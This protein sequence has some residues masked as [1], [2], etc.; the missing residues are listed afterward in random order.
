MT[1]STT[2][3]GERLVDAREI[4]PRVRH[5][6]IL[7]MFGL[8][9]PGEGFRI[10]NDHDPRRLYFEFQAQHGRGFEWTY[11]EQGPDEWKIRIGRPLQTRS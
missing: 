11:L 9:A 10:L 2:E 7:Q 4:L 8:L 5:T 6:V 3:E 1:G